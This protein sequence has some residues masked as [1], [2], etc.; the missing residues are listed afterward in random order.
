MNIKPGDAVHYSGGP[1]CPG[2]QYR[3]VLAVREGQVCIDYLGIPK[4]IPLSS[5]IGVVHPTPDPTPLPSS[6]ID[7]ARIRTKL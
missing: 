4:W 1:N 2:D 3:P 6:I 5:V 7:V